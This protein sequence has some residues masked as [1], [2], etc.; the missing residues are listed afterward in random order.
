MHFVLINT[1]IQSSRRIQHRL[2]G[3]LRPPSADAPL[4]RK[5]HTGF[6]LTLLGI[7]LGITV[8]LMS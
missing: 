8:Y 1:F 3:N 4:P 6:I 2:L 5:D 7:T